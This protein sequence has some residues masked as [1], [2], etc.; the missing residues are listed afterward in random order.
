[1]PDIEKSFKVY[2]YRD[3]IS[4]KDFLDKASAEE[5]EKIGKEFGLALKKLHGIKPTEK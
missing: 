1:M 4:L 3:E 5:E 2:E